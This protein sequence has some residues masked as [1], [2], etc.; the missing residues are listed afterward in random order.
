MARLI[1][2]RGNARTQ[3]Q[4]TVLVEE[5]FAKSDSAAWLDLSIVSKNMRNLYVLVIANEQRKYPFIKV[6]I[7]L[8]AGKET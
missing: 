1:A 4:C 3:A 6:E 8:G 5:I 2:Y 7:R